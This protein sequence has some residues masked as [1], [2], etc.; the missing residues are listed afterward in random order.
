MFD[1]GFWKGEKHVSSSLLTLSKYFSTNVNY[2][3][4]NNN[5]NNNDNNRCRRVQGIEKKKINNDV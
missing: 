2:Y 5:N 4:N 1:Q 3:T